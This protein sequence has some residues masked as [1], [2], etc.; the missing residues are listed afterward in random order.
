MTSGMNDIAYDIS[1]LFDVELQQT[2]APGLRAVRADCIAA[3]TTPPALSITTAQEALARELLQSA[4]IHEEMIQ[5][6]LRM[7]GESFREACD[8]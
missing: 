3:A 5:Q 7:R 6:Y 2:A 1:H 4:P 8:E